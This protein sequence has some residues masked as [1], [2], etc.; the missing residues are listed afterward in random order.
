MVKACRFAPLS[1]LICTAVL[2]FPEARAPG[3]RP[4]GPLALAPSQSASSA[5]T[6]EGMQSGVASHPKG[7]TVPGY[8]PCSVQTHRWLVQAGPFPGV[9]C[10]HRQVSA[11]PAAVWDQGRP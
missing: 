6:G 2:L 10:I 9:A 1:V 5:V 8:P 11:K 3:V 7:S 4:W